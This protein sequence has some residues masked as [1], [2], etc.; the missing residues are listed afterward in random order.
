[1]LG[2]L[3]KRRTY[4]R[5][6]FSRSTFY[7]CMCTHTH[8]PLT[9]THTHTAMRCDVKSPI[10]LSLPPSEK[11]KFVIGLSQSPIPGLLFPPL[12]KLGVLK[13]ECVSDSSRGLV[14]TDSWAPLQEFVNQYMRLDPRICISN[15]FPRNAD[16]THPG[17]I[18]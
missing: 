13:F 8:T 12:V 14:Q 15:K 7:T 5:K 18:L 4:L 9:H 17:T 10:S 11:F 6:W 1:M 16:A 3:G 2:W